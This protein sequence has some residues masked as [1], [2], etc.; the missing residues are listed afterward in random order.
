MTLLDYCS[1]KTCLQMAEVSTS[2]LG[3]PRRAIL[4][5]EPSYPNRR[6]PLRDGGP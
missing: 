6:R 1:L 5:A 4:R 2:S 3:A